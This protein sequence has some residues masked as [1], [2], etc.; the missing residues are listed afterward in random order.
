MKVYECQ[1]Q[2]D[3]IDDLVSDLSIDIYLDTAN[4]DMIKEHAEE[5]YIK[6]FTSNPSLMAKYGITSYENF[7]KEFLNISQDKP[8][9]FEVC[10]DELNLM[11]EQALRISKFSDN[12][13]VKIPYYNTKGLNTLELINNLTK[14]K[15]KTNVTAIMSSNQIKSIVDTK[16]DDTESILSIFAG[17]IADSG[18]DPKNTIKESVNYIKE[19]KKNFKILWASVREIYNL[20]EADSCGSNIITITPELISKIKLRHKDLKEYSI[21]TSKMFYQ[22]ALK[23]KLEI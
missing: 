21:E 7:I 12:I 1:M 6:G 4:L 8:V 2:K 11:H 15:I 18:R 5:N 10:A 14:E 13:Y 23:N 17:R 22:D 3:T 16:E 9:S 20:Y 19:S